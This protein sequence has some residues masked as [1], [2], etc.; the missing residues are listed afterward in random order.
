[1]DKNI[2]IAWIGFAGVVVAAII[3]IVAARV[4]RQSRS[5]DDASVMLPYSLHRDE[6]DRKESEIKKLI[7]SVVLLKNGTVKDSQDQK[8]RI[9]DNLTD[10]FDGVDE[11]NHLKLEVA[12]KDDGQAAIFY[13][14]RIK[15][16]ITRVEY[17][18]SEKMM[19][20][21][22]EGG[23][24]RPI[25]MPLTDEVDAKFV[26]KRPDKILFV[27]MSDVTGE[28]VEGQYVPLKIYE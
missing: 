12:I 18:A 9:N 27:L 7:E 25:G 5:D 2:L 1:M 16:M 28:A 11:N 23:S 15:N 13:D 14:K 6:L 24:R 10:Y 19:V 21:L 26:A 8:R 17:F 22:T 4:G 20:F 3:G